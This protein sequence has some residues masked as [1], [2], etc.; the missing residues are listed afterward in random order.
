MR[1]PAFLRRFEAATGGYFSPVVT[2]FLGLNLLILV[3]GLVA[4][5]AFDVHMVS[6]FHFSR[7]DLLAGR[8]WRL[9]TAPVMHGNERHL[10]Y[11][12]LIL[13]FFGHVVE[14][15]LGSAGLI[16]MT[17]MTVIISGLVHAAF[18][19]SPYIGFSGVSYAILVAFATIAPRARVVLLVFFMPAWLLATIIISLDLLGLLRES[20]VAHLIHLVGAGIG[21]ASIRYLGYW[22][23]LGY[24]WR[25]ARAER[26]AAHDALLDQEL[27][28]LLAKV[29]DQGLTSLT[30]SERTFLQRY[31][32]HRRRQEP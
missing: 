32:Q 7:E 16:R 19:T 8:L 23:R 17:L 26:L 29:S 15:Q 20:Q 14:R 24:R 30:N 22:R 10:L 18:Y 3:L 13:G 2:V 25:R 27:D 5:L 28:R 4:A 21:F 31:A 9:F 6:A 12:M 1:T 11:N